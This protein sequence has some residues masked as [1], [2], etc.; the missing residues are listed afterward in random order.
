MK[1]EYYKNHGYSKYFITEVSEEA[2]SKYNAQVGQF[3][4]RAYLT[5]EDPKEIVGISYSEDRINATALFTVGMIETPFYHLSYDEE[6][7]K[8]PIGETQKRKATFVKYDTGW[9][10]DHVE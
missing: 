1:D 3:R 4:G 10:F 6:Q 2:K 9:V 5:L 8:C 7:N